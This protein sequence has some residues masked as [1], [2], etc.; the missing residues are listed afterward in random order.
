MLPL[1]GPAVVELPAASV[2]TRESVDASLVSVLAATSVLNE[3]SSRAGDGVAI[4]TNE[5]R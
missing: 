2:T 3:S 4:L 5:T 1:I